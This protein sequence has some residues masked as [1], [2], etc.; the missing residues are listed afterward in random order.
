MGFLFAAPTMF[1]TILWQVINQ[2][3][4]AILNFGNANKSSPASASDIMKSY[5]MAVVASCSAGAAIR[6]AS[7]D[8]TAKAHG[9]RLIVLN[10]IVSTIACAGGGF[11]NNWFIRQPEVKTGIAIVDPASEKVVGVS[12]NCA[13][14]AVWQTAL[15]RLLMPLT[16]G[17]PGFAI[18]ALEK[19][20][21]VP[22]NAT[23]LL[24]LQLTL[25]SM[26]LTL[27][28]PLSMA[29]FPQVRL[30]D[31]DQLEPEFQNL[32]SEATGEVIKQFRYNK[33]L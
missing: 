18:Y 5:A 26:Q 19:K 13:K 14:S 27:S 7:K 9:G 4:N 31:A 2:T 8:L 24:I 21:L 22:K 12:K 23:L 33:G 25:I 6:Y 10:A 29:A 3:Y 32:K 30:M 1:N 20:H 17:L 11:A 15:S 16:L 28:V